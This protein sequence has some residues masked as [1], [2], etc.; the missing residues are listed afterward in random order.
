MI[1]NRPPNSNS[2][3]QNQGINK[4]SILSSMTPSKEFRGEHIKWIHQSKDV[5]DQEFI[6]QWASAAKNPD[7][8]HFPDFYIGYDEKFYHNEKDKR[9]LD[10]QTQLVRQNEI[11]DREELTER[12][13]ETYEELKKEWES[14]RSMQETNQKFK[15]LAK[16]TKKNIKSKKITYD[17]TDSESV[18]S[19][20][21]Y[22]DILHSDEIEAEEESKRP[23]PNEERLKLVSQSQLVLED[24]QKFGFMGK[25]IEKLV[26]TRGV[27]VM[28][29]KDDEPFLLNTYD[30]LPTRYDTEIG[31]YNYEFRATSL[32]SE[33]PKVIR[34][35]EISNEKITAEL[36]SRIP[37]DRFPKKV[38]IQEAGKFLKQYRSID[39]SED[40][41]SD[42][43]YYI[44]INGDHNLIDDVIY[45]QSN[46]LDKLNEI[47]RDVQDSDDE[48][49]GKRIEEQKERI[50]KL[51]SIKESLIKK[52]NPIKPD[53]AK[54]KARPSITQIK[55]VQGE[56]KGIQV[57]KTAPVVNPSK[58]SD[59]LKGLLD[60]ENDED[61]EDIV[62]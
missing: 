6:D 47:Q 3:L 61:D 53:I 50:A 45:E 21:S 10:E 20:D 8:S 5:N 58:V 1:N 49:L 26:K 37:F 31:S 43:R 19:S 25:K 60:D 23:R 38:E 7:L 46:L 13:K 15:A 36:V 30:Q 55:P 57:S 24:F 56:N 52:A 34:V 17:S 42:K 41:Y 48:D 51:K 44:V 29:K 12:L 18:N 59:A 14:S 2:L 16:N 62:L 27:F 39:N 22:S 4:E 11:L 33:N 32:L 9:A 40:Y 28:L 54:P 35:D